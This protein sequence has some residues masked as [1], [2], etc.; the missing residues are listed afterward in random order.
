MFEQ[1]LQLKKNKD[2]LNISD[3][4]MQLFIDEFKKTVLEQP[5]P[6]VLINKIF[7]KIQQND[8]SSKIYLLT[9][10]ANSEDSAHDYWNFLHFYLEE[11]KYSEVLKCDIRRDFIKFDIIQ[12]HSYIEGTTNKD[13]FILI[14]I[15]LLEKLI[16]IT[17]M[18][19]EIINDPTKILNYPPLSDKQLDEEMKIHISNIIRDKLS[20]KPYK[21]NPKTYMNYVKN[22]LD[23]YK[24][25][26]IIDFINDDK[27]IE[28]NI[29]ENDTPTQIITKINNNSLDINSAKDHFVINT[30]D[31]FVKDVDNYLTMLYGV[32][33]DIE[34]I[35]Q[36]K[37][38]ENIPGDELKVI[39]IYT[40]SMH[41]IVYEKLFNIVNCKA[42]KI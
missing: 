2:I 15:Q 40:G 8:K 12:Q 4:E 37:R 33:L 11:K 25:K 3:E 13:Y 34:V 29:T 27:K 36:M 9:E 10:N 31:E 23:S 1:T 39:I 22:F 19:D 24:N 38:I 14:T 5:T 28:L 6:V 16:K 7:D 20:H 35:I 42:E 18:T 32:I 30:V 41:T 21:N 26:K 17:N